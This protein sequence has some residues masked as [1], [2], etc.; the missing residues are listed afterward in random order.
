MTIDHDRF[1]RLAAVSISD[2]LEPDDELDLRYH[3][4]G[5]PRCK[6]EHTALQSDHRRLR[7]V[8]TPRP[9]PDAVRA[10]VIGHARGRRESSPWGLLLVASL[11]V[12]AI[13]AIVVVAGQAKPTPPTIGFIGT[14]TTR[15]CATW[16]VNAATEDTQDC[17]RWGDGTELTL[18]IDAADPGAV[19]LVGPNVVSCT[20]VPDR[21]RQGIPPFPGAGNYMLVHLEST[22]CG[23][24]TL[25]E[26]ATLDFYRDFGSDTIWLDPDGDGWGL[27]WSRVT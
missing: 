12:I 4:D 19:T 15:D 3:L 18:R 27:N 16:W 1:V 5:C 26:D 7:L 2:A 8:M 11:V 10:T 13:A 20:G 25:A 14:W 24:I 22:A 6:T 21:P 9:V 23:D 17:E